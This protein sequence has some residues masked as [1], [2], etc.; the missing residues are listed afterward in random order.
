MFMNDLEVPEGKSH[1]ISN[2]CHLK[3]V[4]AFEGLERPTS[5]SRLLAMILPRYICSQR[6][7]GHQWYRQHAM[8]C[9]AQHAYVLVFRRT[10]CCRSIA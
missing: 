8:I 10:G 6:T 5:P 1:S 4:D 7:E 3:R 2:D 9:N